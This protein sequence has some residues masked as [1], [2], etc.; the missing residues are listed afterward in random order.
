MLVDNIVDDST[1]AAYPL[2]SKSVVVLEIM[3]SK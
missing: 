1:I 2:N 3:H